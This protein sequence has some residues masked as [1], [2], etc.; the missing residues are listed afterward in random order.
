MSPAMVRLDEALRVLEAYE[1]VTARRRQRFLSTKGS[2]RIRWRAMWYEA[3]EQLEAAQ[4]RVAELTGD[5]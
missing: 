4:K 5:V 2:E 3:I 1:I